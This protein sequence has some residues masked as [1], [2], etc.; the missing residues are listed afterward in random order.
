MSNWSVET[1]KDLIGK[2]VLFLISPTLSVIY[3]FKRANTKSSYLIFFL[4]SVLFGLAFIAETPTLSASYIDSQGYRRQFERYTMLTDSYFL[5]RLNEY[6][7]Y[8]SKIKDFY[9]ETIT[10]FVSRVTDNYHFLF[11]V[12][13]IVFSYFALKSFRFFTSEKSFDSSIVTYILTYLFLF[14]DIFNINGV[15]FWTASWIAIYCIFQIIKKE[16]NKY[17]LLAL[18]TPF[19]HGSFWLFIAILILHQVSKKFD[20]FWITMFLLS[21]VFSNFSLVLVQSFTNT[22]EAY[23]PSFIL[24]LTKGYTDINYINSRSEW[25]GYGW[26]YVTFDYIKQAYLI[27]LFLIIMSK[28]KLVL[29]NP[30]TKN[31]YYFFIIWV[32][33]FN[34]LTAIPSLGGRFLVLSYP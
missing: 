24:N 34:F 26:I 5:D 8:N 25:S 11:M 14:N 10:F 32:T 22:F 27:G 16:N 2:L 18:L 33:C 29:A 7:S 15:R 20:R 23:L 13:A 9:Y 30:T 31:M 1:K 4:T 28:R 19:V 17:Y 6:L 21:I 3:S 12:F